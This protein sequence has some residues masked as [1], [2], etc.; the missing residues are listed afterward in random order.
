MKKIARI[1]DGTREFLGEVR[2]EAHKSTWP[3]RAELMAH[4]GIVIV[5]VI[6]LGVFIGL[7]DWVLLGLVR[8]FL[9]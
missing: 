4:T 5:F 9:G 8:L 7:S 6:I 3:T 1:V 2:L